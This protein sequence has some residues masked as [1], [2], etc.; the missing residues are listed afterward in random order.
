MCVRLIA[1]VLYIY[2]HTCNELVIVWLS[3]DPL[4]CVGA[5]EGVSD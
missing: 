3:I 2:Q 1:I 4:K 5:T